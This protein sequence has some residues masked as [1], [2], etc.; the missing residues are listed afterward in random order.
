MFS[1]AS[2]HVSATPS[3]FW[4]QLPA[5]VNPFEARTEFL[6]QS[7]PFYS[8]SHL[9]FSISPAWWDIPLA[10]KRNSHQRNDLAADWGAELPPAAAP[11]GAAAWAWGG[12]SLRIKSPAARISSGVKSNSGGRALPFGSRV[13]GSRNSSK[14]TW[15]HDCMGV[16]RRSGVYTSNFDIRSTASAGAFDLKTCNTAH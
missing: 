12:T 6:Q 2:P 11:T 4:E 8:L 9:C 1:G 15:A 13:F 16:I 3:R 7:K 10:Y 14:K 5:S